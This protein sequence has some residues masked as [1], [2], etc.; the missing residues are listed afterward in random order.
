MA[1]FF[2][3]AAECGSEREAAEV[4]GNHFDGFRIVLLAASKELSTVCQFEVWQ[5]SEGNWWCIVV[6]SGVSQTGREDNVIKSQNQVFEVVEGLYERLKT[7]P[8]FRYAVVGFEVIP[9][10]TYSELVEAKGPAHEPFGGLV[11][12]QHLWE[13][14]ERPSG[15]VKFS[16][17]AYWFPF[18]KEDLRCG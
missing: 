15:Y 2:E 18:R 16:E 17:G 5:D 10:D 1:Y 8:A 11:L 14:I 12:D 9:F 3:L 7:A 13:E 4:F 6:P